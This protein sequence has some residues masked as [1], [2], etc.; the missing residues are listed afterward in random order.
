MC[1]GSTEETT[2]GRWA[3]I[4]LRWGHPTYGV[5]RSRVGSV[6]TGFHLGDCQVGPQGGSWCMGRLKAVCSG[7]GP[8]NPCAEHVATSDS[9]GNA[10]LRLIRCHGHNPVCQHVAMWPGV[11]PTRPHMMSCAYL[12][13]PGSDVCKWYIHFDCLDEPIAMVQTNLSFEVVYDDVQYKQL[14][15]LLST[16][17]FNMYLGVPCNKS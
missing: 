6:R 4:A 13:H 12:S 15:C 5:S 17:P 11:G 16:A 8:L 9:S 1:L 3:W 10:S 2:R 7:C 14:I